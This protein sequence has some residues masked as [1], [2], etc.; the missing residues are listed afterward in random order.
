MYLRFF[1]GEEYKSA[2]LLSFFSLFFFSPQINWSLKKQ[3]QE[4]N[5]WMI[6]SG[7]IKI[8]RIFVL[9]AAHESPV[10]WDLASGF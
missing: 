10:I 3:S 9:L 6:L 4:L 2:K 7:A 5:T 1:Q 8:G